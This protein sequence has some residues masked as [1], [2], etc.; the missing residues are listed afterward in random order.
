MK[1][2]QRLKQN[3]II[4]AQTMKEL[5]AKEKRLKDMELQQAKTMLEITKLKGSN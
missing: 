4:Q 3:E 2:E 5:T 1:K